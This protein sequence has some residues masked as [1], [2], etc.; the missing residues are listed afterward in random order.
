MTYVEFFSNA[1]PIP[2]LFGGK[3]SNLIKLLKLGLNIPPGFIVNTKSYNKFLEDSH[4]KEQIFQILSTEYEQKDVLDLS[5]KI[6]NLFINS[7][8]PQKIINEIKEAYQNI[9]KKIG[10]KISFSVRTSANVEDLKDF[11]FAGQAESFLNKKTLEE[12]LESLKNCWISLFSPQAL[13]YIL[14]TR[15]YNKEISLIDLKM[16]VIIQKMVSSQISGVLF[17]ANVLNNS[18]N[19]MLINSTWGLGDTITNG[20]TIPD[21]I[22]LKKDPFSIIKIVIGK[23]EKKSI[24]NPYGSSTILIETEQELKDRCSLNE[25]QLRNLYNLGLKLEYSFNYP[26][27]IEWAIENEILYTLQCRPITTLR[28]R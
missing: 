15:K 26:Q 3:G 13:L 19:Q 9:R 11:S 5:E 18:Q 17:T 27:D 6:K 12:I 23:K 25:S 8:I 28:K 4:L 2:N 14:Q 20:T 16:A 22:V 1:K 24:S 7:K 21:L 10:K